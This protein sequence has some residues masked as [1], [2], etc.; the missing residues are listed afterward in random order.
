MSK[1]P[2]NVIVVFCFFLSFFTTTA[3]ALGGQRV[4][5][6]IQQCQKDDPAYLYC[7]GMG[8]GVSLMMMLN[9]KTVGAYRFC[10]ENRSRVLSNGQIIRIFLNWA[11]RNPKNWDAPG[12]IGFALALEEAYPCN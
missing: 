8:S 10:R 5:D 9:S 2:M 6:M 4:Q 12:P 7:V 1:M 11:D 3:N